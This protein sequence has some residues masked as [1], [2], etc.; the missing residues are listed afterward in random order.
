MTLLGFR[1]RLRD[2]LQ[3][4]FCRE[5]LLRA[6]FL[7][8]HRSS[9]FAS[10][11][12]IEHIA[13]N[14]NGV[15]LSRENDVENIFHEPPPSRPMRPV[16]T[17]RLLI[18]SQNCSR[19]GNFFCGLV[20]CATLGCTQAVFAQVDLDNSGVSQSG[21]PFFQEREKGW[22]WYERPPV[23]PVDP[24]QP[25]ITPPT[26]APA[27]VGPASP[28]PPPLSAEWLRGALPMLRDAAIDAPTEDNVAAY[29]YAQRI[30]MDK[31][32]MFSDVAQRVVTSDPLL[33]E[34]L[35]LP[36]ASAAKTSMLAHATEVKSEIV[37]DLGD[38]VGL[39]FFYD[40]SCEYC[41]RQLAPINQLA[42]KHANVAI[43]II[44]KQG[45]AITGLNPRI[46][47]LP[48]RGQFANLGINFTPS[49]MMMVP[50]D[51]FYLVSQ[52]YT[53]YTSLIDKLVGA[54]NEYGLIPTEQ[55]YAAEPTARGI[56]DASRVD[57]QEIAVDWDNTA[58]WVPFIRE[59]IART[60]GIA[61]EDTEGA[62]DE[63]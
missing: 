56:I 8:E 34:N 25:P 55:Y 44:H 32:Q 45:G 62:D 39:W 2:A 13:V 24:E 12:G 40:G 57:Q 47:I 52:G 18:I 38:Q 33:D 10:A 9:R 50:P 53:S 41:D 63:Q 19:Q 46:K 15:A 1:F 29:F 30:M 42:N 5:H 48:D 16:Q 3:K 37:D 31:A 28:A 21:E 36:F 4:A 26:Q 22:H 54:A 7:K 17:R 58:S 20:L 49:I 6:H 60:Y 43:Q 14:R 35:R 51:G 61:T 23:E 59:Q 27:T 11:F